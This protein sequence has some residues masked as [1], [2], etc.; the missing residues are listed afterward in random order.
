MSDSIQFKNHPFR[1]LLYL[2]WTLLGIAIF[3][4]LLSTPGQ[5]FSPRFPEL[6]I[7]SLI[8]FGLMGLRLP[9]SNQLSKI[10]YTSCEVLLILITIFF[11]GRASRLFPFIYLILVTRSCLIFQLPGRLI[12]TS[13]SFSLFIFTISRKFYR[14]GISPAAQERF[15]F[16]T[17]SFI[18]MFGL[19]LVF[20]LLLMN[21]IVSERQSR[22]KLA[23]ANEKL[24]QYALK[25]EH[26]ATLEE[27]NR[28]AREIHDSLGHSLT[29][30]NLQLETGLKLWQTN[31]A[32]AHDFLARAKQLGSKALQDVRQ[33]VS[34]IRSRSNSFGGEQSESIEEAIIV[35]LEDVERAINVKPT[36]NLNISYVLPSEISIAVY[37][38]IQESLTNICKYANATEV[39]LE[40]STSSVE[41]NLQIKDNGIGFEL[42]QNTTGFGLQSM[43]DR[44]ESLGG[45]FNIE[46]SF[47]NGCK[48]QVKIPICNP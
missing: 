34:T 16:F 35:L 6:T 12:V 13:L 40:L 1:F 20:I 23:A 31:P 47:G 21:A 7:C 45:K 10:T 24:K 17:L 46:T 28:I 43:R 33:S 14:F 42:N 38:V 18:V 26:Q 36:Y 27:R 30:L 37:R 29:A 19:S 22:E 41:L 11:G 39:K 2:E 8:I 44:T 4:S 5:R 3:S 15:R 48:V 32:K 9:T 25:V